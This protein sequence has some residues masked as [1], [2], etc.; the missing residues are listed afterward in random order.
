MSDRA[1]FESV[2]RAHVGAVHAYALRR[3]DAA[4]ADE[5]V[6]DT[7]LVCW[8]RFDRVPDDVLPW[9]YAV[10]RRCLANRLRAGRREQARL[11]P[12]APAGTDPTADT[13]EQRARAR[14]VLAALAGLPAKEREALQL[15][16]WEG[17][18]PAE[19]ARVVG[20]TAAAF[21]VRLH[22]ARRRLAATLDATP[23]HDLKEAI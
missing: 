3:S 5:V 16:A 21:R 22:R 13:Y 18:T 7:F 6:A 2:F 4:T 11:A 9:L 10:A 23:T 20:C 15:C 12:A 8:R 19:G 1:A 14:E 17:L